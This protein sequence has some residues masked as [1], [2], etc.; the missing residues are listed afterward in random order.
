MSNLIFK[1][2]NPDEKHDAYFFEDFAKSVM[3]NKCEND[4][5]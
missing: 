2:V 4:G 1:K 3:K 5:K